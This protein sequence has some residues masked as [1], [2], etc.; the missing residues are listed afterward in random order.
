MKVYFKI[1]KENK[2]IGIEEK[3]MVRLPEVGDL[4]ILKHNYYKVKHIVTDI[5]CEK[6]VSYVV[7]CNYYADHTLNLDGDEENNEEN[8]KI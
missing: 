1:I 2:I 7:F 6:G 3:D 4:I 5:G 8:N